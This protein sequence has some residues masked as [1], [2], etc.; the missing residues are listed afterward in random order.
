MLVDQDKG[1]YDLKWIYYM[2]D[3]IVFISVGHPIMLTTISKCTTKTARM[4]IPRALPDLYV[5]DFIMLIFSNI[6]H[7]IETGRR[8]GTPFNG[9]KCND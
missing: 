2:N 5:Q 9:R 3:M 1:A 4:A 6:G 7:P 8:G